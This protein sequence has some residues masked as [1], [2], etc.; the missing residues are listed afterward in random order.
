M[1]GK[2]AE[3]DIQAFVRVGNLAK[4]AGQAAVDAALFQ[5]DE[6]RALYAAYE[7]ADKAAAEKLQAE[8]YAGAL[9]AFTQLSQPIDAFFDGV[10]VMDK[11]EKIRDNRLGLL[12]SIDALVKR[13]AD[14]SKIVTA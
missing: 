8:D 14:F 6:E 9:E 1:A 4:K 2:D 7:E 5:N 3:K 10:M 13:V 12:K 11:D